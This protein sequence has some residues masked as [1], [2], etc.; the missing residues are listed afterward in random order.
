M[1]NAAKN[2]TN[3]QCLTQIYYVTW[4]LPCTGGR[5]HLCPA[6]HTSISKPLHDPI[7]LLTS[8]S[9]MSRVKDISKLFIVQAFQQSKLNNAQLLIGQLLVLCYSQAL[10]QVK[11]HHSFNLESGKVQTGEHS[12]VTPNSRL[13]GLFAMY[14]MKSV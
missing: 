4:S 10:S 8:H 14:A 7:V 2:S 13:C 12:H 3:F 11:L 6:P 9:Q 5:A 1:R